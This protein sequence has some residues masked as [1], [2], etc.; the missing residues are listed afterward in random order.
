MQENR[1]EAA[2]AYSV[3]L[4]PPKYPWSEDRKFVL[5]KLDELAE[6]QSSNTL[7]LSLLREKDL[8]EIRADLARLEVLVE[9]IR[10]NG[11]N[12]KAQTKG[13][14]VVVQEVK[15]K[16]QFYLALVMVVYSVA[17]RWF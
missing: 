9:A 14:A 5:E 15:E 12:G 11:S 7:N 1:L 6:G 2:P 13:A 17:E 16:W 4:M 8:P 3:L 10:K